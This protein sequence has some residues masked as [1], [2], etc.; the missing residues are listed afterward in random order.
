MTVLVHY[1]DKVLIWILFCLN[2]RKSTDFV[3]NGWILHLI[4]LLMWLIEEDEIIKMLIFF[5]IYPEIS[6]KW[7]EASLPVQITETEVEEKQTSGFFDQNP[8]REKGGVKNG[9]WTRRSVERCTKLHK[10]NVPVG[11]QVWG[12]QKTSQSCGAVVF[13]GTC[14]LKTSWGQ[15]TRRIISEWT[16]F[17]SSSII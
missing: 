15:K 4:Y 7:P 6:Q 1:K 13:E 8:S 14:S 2:Q 12:Q 11:L 5:V 3:E 10:L 9:I 16:V 17:I